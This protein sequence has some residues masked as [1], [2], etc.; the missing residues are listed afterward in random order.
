MI[1]YLCKTSWALLLRRPFEAAIQCLWLFALLLVPVMVLV[2][3]QVASPYWWTHPFDVEP[4]EHVELKPNEP[5]GSKRD[6][7][8]KVGILMTHKAIE[9][10]RRSSRTAKRAFTTSSPAPRL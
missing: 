6:Q 5:P 4:P 3:F 10:K 7:A 8:E 2:V 9:R 1:G